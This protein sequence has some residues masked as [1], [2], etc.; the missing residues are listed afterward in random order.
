VALILL[1]GS[2]RV[3][4][5]TSLVFACICLSGVIVTGYLGQ[6]SLAQMS[7]AGLGGF[8]L[9]H[10]TSGLGLGFPIAPLLAALGAAAGGVLVGLPAVRIRGV[11][12]AVVTLAAAA[13]ADSILF[14][15]AWFGG[16][17]QGLDI[18]APTLFGLDLGI[19][20]S[21]PGDYPRV[22]FGILVL[23]VVT[24]VALFIARLRRGAA[25][26][27]FVAVRSNELAAAAMGIDVAA[28]KLLAFALSAFVAGVGGALLAYQ[29]TTVA[30][31]SFAVLT[32]VTILAITYVAGIARISGAF[33]AGITLAAGGLAVT[34]LNKIIDF[35][36]YQPLVAGLGLIAIAIQHPDGMA[37]ALPDLSRLRAWAH[38]A[39]AGAPAEPP[40][41]GPD[42]TADVAQGTSR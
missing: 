24:A 15:S 17:A 41:P 40:A 32:S 5:V 35:G 38:R 23:V 9:A 34:A 20:G 30:P 36:A 8:L 19:S 1:Q 18:G 13:A 27:M 6:V 7:F 3:A 29:Q 16:D 22:T 37:S 4:L 12:L 31:Q 39:G 33:V 25:G 21:S 42:A 26:R 10:I 2:L 28:T 14:G 11:N